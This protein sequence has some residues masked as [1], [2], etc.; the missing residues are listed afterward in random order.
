MNLTIMVIDVPDKDI[1]PIMLDT[2]ADL[3]SALR[4]CKGIQTIITKTD[5]SLTTVYKVLDE[6]D[7]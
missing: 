5:R 7:E 1:E 4:E 6:S 2:I 3:Q